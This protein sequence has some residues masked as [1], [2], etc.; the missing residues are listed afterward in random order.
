[1]GCEVGSCYVAPTDGG[2]R[3]IGHVCAYHRGYSDG[4]RGLH[5]EDWEKP[6][7][8]SAYWKGHELGLSDRVAGQTDKDEHGRTGTETSGA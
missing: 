5:K 8:R 3:R 2:F 7:H 6:G 1:M 4:R